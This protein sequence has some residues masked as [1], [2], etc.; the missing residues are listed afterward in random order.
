MVVIQSANVR[1]QSKLLLTQFRSIFLYPELNK[2]HMRVREDR[3]ILIRVTSRRWRVTII[4]VE[5]QK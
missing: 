5:K 2:L 4:A 1:E 3:Q